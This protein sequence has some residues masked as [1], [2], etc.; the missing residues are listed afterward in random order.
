MGYDTG[1]AD[2][3]RAKGLKVVEVAGWQTRGSSS[4]NPK[5]FVWHHTA[6]PS[7]GNAPSL[8]ICTYGRA[9]LAGPLCNV[10]QA[11]DNTIYVVAAGR[12]NHAGEGSWKGLSGNSSV[13]GVE[14]ENV[15]T[16][17]EPWRQ[18][19]LDTAAKVAA[20]LAASP[21]LSCHHKEWTRRKVD[22]HTVGGQDMRART[23][24]V[25]STPAPKPPTGGTKP[26]E[27]EDTMATAYLRLDQPGHKHHGRIEAVGDFHRRHIGTPG[28]LNTLVFF[29]AK[30]QNVNAEVWN[31]LTANKIVVDARGVSA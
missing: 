2:R 12:A 28:E 29:G 7:K 13:Y 11:R 23:E 20:A 24:R 8:T 26:Q 31:N 9:G 25:L 27:S 16:S 3:L 1:I 30:V 15:G 5:G 6:G 14:I 18:D 17:A 4:F 19:Q 10:F 21:G 22:M